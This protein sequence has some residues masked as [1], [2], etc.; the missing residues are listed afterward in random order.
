MPRSVYSAESK[1]ATCECW[2]V[3][4]QWS[5]PVTGALPGVACRVCSGDAPTTVERGQVHVDDRAVANSAIAGHTFALCRLR[6]GRHL[7]LAI[8]T[9][10][11]GRSI[12]G[13]G[14]PV[15]CRCFPASCSSPRI[16]HLGCP[17]EVRSVLGAVLLVPRSVGR[18]GG[19]RGRSWRGTSGGVATCGGCH[20][21]LQCPHVAVD[22]VLLHAQDCER[23]TDKQYEKPT[24]SLR[25]V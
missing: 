21:P 3:R 19:G 8:G 24:K 6:S 13:Q 25:H 2:I 10:E 23:T 22:L 4:T 16:A 18:R 17:P 15:E 11:V 12:S 5:H 14:C 9:R 20:R 7:P 1:R